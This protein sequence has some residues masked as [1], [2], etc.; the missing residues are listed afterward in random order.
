MV[1][2]LGHVTLEEPPEEVLTDLSSL[3]IYK[4]VER[5]E[6]FHYDLLLIS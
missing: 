4:S 6:I 3:L 2:H 1:G 5:P